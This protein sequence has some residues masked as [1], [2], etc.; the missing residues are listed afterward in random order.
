MLQPGT[1]NRNEAFGTCRIGVPRRQ[2]MENQSTSMMS[3]KVAM[4][5]SA[6]E[7]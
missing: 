6:H 3:S 4:I 2:M 1:P 5:E 7:I